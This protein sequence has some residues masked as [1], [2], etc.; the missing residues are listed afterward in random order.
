MSFNSIKD[1]VDNSCI[2]IQGS[3][4]LELLSRVYKEVH[5]CPVCGKKQEG[6]EG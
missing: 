4:L 5:Y 1:F 3:E 6:I 2:H